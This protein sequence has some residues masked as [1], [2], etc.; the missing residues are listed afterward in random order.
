MAFNDKIND[1]IE[2]MFTPPNPTHVVFQKLVNKAV[3]NY[4]WNSNPD[5][6]KAKHSMWDEKTLPGSYIEELT[7]K[8]R[9]DLSKLKSNEN[10][11]RLLRR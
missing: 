8:E 2:E 3:R 7:E 6:R 9:E 1:N 5:W 4:C 10:I 11:L